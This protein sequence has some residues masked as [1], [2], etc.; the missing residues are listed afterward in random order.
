MNTKYDVYMRAAELV[1][2]GWCQGEMDDE[3]GKVCLYGAVCKAYYE[4]GP[5]PIAGFDYLFSIR[6]Q[7]I[8]D[9]AVHI[10]R[11]PFFWYYKHQYGLEN[12][13]VVIYWNDLWWRRQRTV[14]ALLERTARSFK[15]EGTE[16]SVAET[17]PKVVELDEIDREF[18][19]LLVEEAYRQVPPPMPER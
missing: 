2:A 13:A 3:A 11:S 9:L 12:C 8:E 7:M 14:V 16:P 18:G 1:R 19:W 17:E 10:K 6:N 5:E 4:L 15:G